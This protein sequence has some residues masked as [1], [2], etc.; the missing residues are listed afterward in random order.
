MQI[1]LV[2]QWYEP[3][4]STV[5]SVLAHQLGKRGHSVKV[6]TGF[7]NYPEGRVYDGY[8][9]A[10]RQDS[11]VSGVPVRRVAL[12]PN[13]GTSAAGRLANYGSFAATAASWGSGF[14]KGVGGA[15]VADSPPTLGLPSWTVQ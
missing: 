10:W 8:R 11:I 4:P 6:L 5:P 2:S 1:G 12:F 14:L 7:P 9:I 15:W 3:E 13:H